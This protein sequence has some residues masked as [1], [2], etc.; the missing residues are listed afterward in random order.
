MATGK[1]KRGKASRAKKKSAP[2][3]RTIQ[4]LIA[5]KRGGGAFT[6]AEI[7]HLIAGYVSGEV[8]DYQMSA[9]AMA[10]Y[11]QGMTPAETA[12]ITLTMRDSGQVL[13]LGSVPG[14]KVDKHSTGGVGDKISICLAPM[15]A[16]CGVPVPMISGRGLGHTGGTV[17]KLEAIEGFEMGRS[18][19][20]FVKQLEKVGCSLYKATEDI[21]PADRRFYALRDVTSTVESIPLITASILS[22][23]L[24][25]G[26]DA[27]VLDVK[28]GR[29]AFMKDQARAKELAK[30]LVR[31]GSLAGKKVSALI[32]NMNAPL[33][34]AVGNANETA[35]AFEVLLGE[36][37]EDI[38]EL[39]LALGAEMLRLGGVARSTAQARKALERSIADGS[40]A[41]KMEAIVKAQGGDPRVVR[42]PDRLPQAKKRAKIVA[43]KAGYVQ[44]IDALEIGWSGVQLGAGRTRSDQAVDPAVG[45][46][47]VKKPGDRVAQGDT[48]ATVHVHALAG[49]K[50]IRDRIAA[51]YT[52]GSRRPAEE[53]LVYEVLRK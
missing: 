29:G 43:P 25:E 27:L 47:L 19:K 37:P 1:S 9:L 31:V 45:I 21:A 51:A 40:A 26:I 50:P 32:T 7:R 20:S 2:V 41:D 28:A 38:R 42:E 53:P 22:K 52:I 18:T 39:T 23:K 3:T 34:L 49:T 6:E 46:M 30:S 24:A 35:E 10:I 8:A 5:H 48:L 44:A 16:A 36:G 11:F 12:A 17:D 15:V 14:V 13:D 33:G 4:E